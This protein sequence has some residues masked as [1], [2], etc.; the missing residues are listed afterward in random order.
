[1]RNE[2]LEELMKREA[3]ENLIRQREIEANPLSQYSNTQLKEE[4]RRRKRQ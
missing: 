1:M 2:R 3:E 4:L